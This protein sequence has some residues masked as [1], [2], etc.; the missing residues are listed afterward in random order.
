MQTFKAKRVDGVDFSP[1]PWGEGRVHGLRAPGR[2]VM[3]V[4]EG[5]GWVRLQDGTRE[6]LTATSV[7]V[8]EPGEWVEYGSNAGEGCKTESYWADDLSEGEWKAI[9]TE[10]FGPDA[11]AD[12]HT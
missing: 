8:W 10:A 9:F 1:N 7:V 6:N 4:R 3:V 2:I 5:S 11:V 12:W